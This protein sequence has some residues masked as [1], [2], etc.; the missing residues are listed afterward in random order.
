MPVGFAQVRASRRPIKMASISVEHEAAVTDKAVRPFLRGTS[1]GGD[2]GI[3]DS[4]A[5]AR[6]I[7][8]RKDG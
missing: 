1:C 2:F 4:D 3:A 8:E 6:F 5:S 7:I